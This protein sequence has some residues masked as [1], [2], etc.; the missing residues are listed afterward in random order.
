MTARSVPSAPPAVSRPATGGRP[1]PAPSER[2][3]WKA[4]ALPAEHGGW[5]LT[6]EP[7][8]LGLLVA[9]SLPGV[10]LALGALVAFLSRTPLKLAVVDHRRHRRL[11]RTRLAERIAAGEVLLLVVLALVATLTAD[12]RFWWVVLAAVPL[13]SLELWFDIRSRGRRLV[14]ELAGS[15]GISAVAAVIVLADGRSAALAVGLWFIAAGR[16]IASVPYA[17]SQVAQLHGRPR[18]LWVSDV[19]QL[20]AVVIAVVAVLL[21]TKLTAGLVAVAI[22]AAYHLVAVRRPSP[23]P[24]IL[25]SVQMTIGF[26]VVLVTWLGAV[27]PW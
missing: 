17:R 26:S 3:A 7:A 9:P 10:A 18:R 14:P 8:L 2:A 27:A 19:S 24:A 25:G 20:T 16:A 5:G 15:A 6:I 11:E 22:V 12:L 13:V 4:V 23:K 21:D 1:R